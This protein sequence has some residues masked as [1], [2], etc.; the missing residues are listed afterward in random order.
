MPR[1]QPLISHL[2]DANVCAA[3]MSPNQ[4]ATE[5][6]PRLHDVIHA[7]RVKGAAAGRPCFLSNSLVEAASKA[8]SLAGEQVRGTRRRGFSGV[9]P[10]CIR[11]TP[12]NV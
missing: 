6:R 8:A 4:L 10:Q 5:V 12:L 7:T 1:Y 11:L 9:A 3:S 2:A